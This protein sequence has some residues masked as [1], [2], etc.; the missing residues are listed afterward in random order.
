LPNLVAWVAL[1]AWPIVTGTLFARLSPAKALVWSVVAGYLLLPEQVSY[2]VTALP[3]LSKQSVIVASALL[4]ALL[5]DR[6][7]SAAGT[8][9]IWIPRSAA[10]RTLILLLL[11]LPL[12]TTLV[13]GDATR[14]GE[15]I[16]P[17]LRLY[18]AGAFFYGQMWKLLPLLLAWR[19]LGDRTGHRIVLRALAAAAVAYSGPIIVELVMSPQMNRWVYGFYQF[20]FVQVYRGGG[21]RPVVFLEHGLWT[22]LFVAMG[23]IG[24][25]A[26]WRI[27]SGQARLLWAGVTAWLG[28]VLVASNSL[29]ALI[30]GALFA[31]V[32]RAAGA[33]AQFVTAA[34]VA[35]VI[36]TY[37]M[38]RSLDFVPTGPILAAA[39]RIDPGRAGSLGYRFDNEDILLARANQRPLFGWGGW[40]R[41]RVYDENSGRDLSVTD[42]RWVIIFGFYGWAGYIAEYGLLTA[43]L[44]LALRRR[45]YL[46]NSPETAGLCLVLAANLV[47][48]I[49]N[50]TVTPVTWLAAGAILG[51]VERSTSEL[52]QGAEPGRAAADPAR[53]P[54]MRPAIGALGDPSR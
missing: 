51:L 1:L 25:A 29:G 50:A 49:P 26:L 40:G 21:Y 45:R 18:D 41:A 19:Y 39:A 17:G 31:P 37:P 46:R 14:I 43:P 16:I 15:R 9:R 2:N 53:R 38:L 34:A 24:A 22:A 8:Q 23:L 44:F 12:I 10:V 30:I 42:G 35:A 13:N 4:F 36:L 6:E 52:A 5:F 3:S 20:S 11:A 33:S 48:T 32:S 47:D 27:A 54:R 7:R 28:L